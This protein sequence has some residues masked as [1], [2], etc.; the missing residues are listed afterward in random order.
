MRLALAGDVML[1]R[2]VNRALRRLPP[3]DLWGD[4]LPLL[5]GADAAICNLECVLSDGGE[6]ARKEFTFRSDAKNVAVLRVAGIDAVS[7]ANNHVLDYGTEALGETLDTLDRAGVAHAGAG[8]AAAAREPALLRRGGATLAMLSATDNEPGWEAGP[9]RL[10]VWYVPVARDDPRAVSLLAAVAATRRTADLLIVAYHWGSN[11]GYQPEPGQGDFARALI[12]AGAD[13]VVGHSCHVARGI[14][15]DRGG[16]IL[17]GT[18]DLIDD[19]A[20][21]ESQPNDESWLFL[22]D[23][24]GG[25]ITELRAHPLL[26]RR[27]RPV[28]AVGARRS[29]MVERMASLCRD[30]GTISEWDEAEGAL[31]VAVGDARGGC[32]RGE[33]LSVS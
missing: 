1:G 8:A 14:E 26:I 10:G 5:R 25:R 21:D 7:L 9:D 17:Y 2:L 27:F 33:A 16:V 3:E 12:E 4:A 15:I 20:V 18:G 30:L 23:A 31:R 24:S 19:Y 6:R 11:W 29:I 32:R 22:V 13:V 28:Q